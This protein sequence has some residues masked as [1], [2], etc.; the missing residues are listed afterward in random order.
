MTDDKEFDR[1][2]ERMRAAKHGKTL[3]INEQIYNE[4]I[5]PKLAEL[6][7]LCS[8]NG[9]SLVASVE[10]EPD[11]L[12]ETRHLA[13]NHTFAS[14]LVSMAIASAGSV[15]ALML[16]I[17]AYAKQHGHTSV[18][19]QLLGKTSSPFGVDRV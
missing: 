4:D 2:Y 1:A 10:Y 6:G 12:G 3:T 14:V 11:Q 13:P 17:S 8:E 19:L 15:D 18:V 16:A 9:M 5:A 7:L